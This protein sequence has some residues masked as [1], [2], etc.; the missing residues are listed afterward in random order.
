MKTITIELTPAEDKA[1]RH[2]AMDPQEWI[3]NAVGHR[4]GTIIDK[5]Y[6]LE[7]EYSVVHPD[8]TTIPT[9]RAQAALSWIIRNPLNGPKYPDEELDP[10]APFQP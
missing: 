5:L 6:N 8:I 2:I 3:N 7:V 10:D 4:V 1:F 9:D